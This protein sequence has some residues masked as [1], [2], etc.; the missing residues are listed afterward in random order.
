[1]VIMYFRK[2]NSETLNSWNP[3]LLPTVLVACM[4]LDFNFLNEEKI[5]ER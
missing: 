4:H 3:T 5:N 2:G 1:M